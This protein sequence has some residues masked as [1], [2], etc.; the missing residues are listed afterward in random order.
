MRDIRNRLLAAKVRPTLQRLEIAAILLTQKQHVSSKQLFQMVNKSFP[1]VA[2]ATIFNTINLFVEKGLLTPVETIGEQI[3]YDSNSEPHHHIIDRKAERV[4][5]I[6]LPPG[7]EKQLAEFY[8][9]E[10]KKCGFNIQK[11]ISIK[12][13]GYI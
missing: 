1:K 6:E 12:V 13:S 10:A 8:Q 7:L 4:V 9:K 5:D 3:L 2:R 11:P